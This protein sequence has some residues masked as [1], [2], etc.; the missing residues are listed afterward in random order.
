MVLELGINLLRPETRLMRAGVGLA[1]D[2]RQP[3][4]SAGGFTKEEEAYVAKI[5]VASVPISRSRGVLGFQHFLEPMAK[6]HTF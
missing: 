3:E 2:L 5:H 1:P 6:P 4:R